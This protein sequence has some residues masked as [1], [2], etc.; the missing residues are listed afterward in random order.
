MGNGIAQ[1]AAQTG[2]DVVAIDVKEEF[3]ERAKSVIGKNLG[4][5]AKKEKI[6][7]EDADA[8]LGRIT[9]TT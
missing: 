2:L 1:V 6:T 3:L 9:F 5:M 7:Q 4:R 8:A